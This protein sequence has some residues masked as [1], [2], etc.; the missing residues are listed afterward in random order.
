VHVPEGHP[1]CAYADS[2]QKTVLQRPVAFDTT[3]HNVTEYESKAVH[4][5]DVNNDHP[6][7]IRVLDHVLKE[8][9]MT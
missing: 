3:M 5:V 4:D 2:G 7:H 9:K 1:I 8:S 6:Y